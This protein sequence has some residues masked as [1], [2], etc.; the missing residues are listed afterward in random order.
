VDGS[1]LP[2]GG[3]LVSGGTATTGQSTKPFQARLGLTTTAG[4]QLDRATTSQGPYDDDDD[5]DDGPDHGLDH[6]LDHELVY[7]WTI[8]YL[9]RAATSQGPYDD[10]DEYDYDYD[11][12]YDYDDGGLDHGLYHGLAPNSTTNWTTTLP[13]RHVVQ[14]TVP[15]VRVASHRPSAIGVGPPWT[16]TRVLFS[17][18]HWLPKH[19]Q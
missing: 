14:E 5:D 9:D 16:L 6:E 4:R 1:R 11:D 18:F 2:A 13:T 15:A 7:G 12:Y 10:D 17:S 8:T 3:G 19:R